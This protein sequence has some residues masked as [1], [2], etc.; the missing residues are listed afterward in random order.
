[1]N[2]RVFAAADAPLFMQLLGDT[3]IATVK[4]AVIRDDR[5]FEI[6]CGKDGFMK[7]AH[8]VFLPSEKYLREHSDDHPVP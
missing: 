6:D 3:C 8:S 2:K 4:V 1:M 7:L 5:L